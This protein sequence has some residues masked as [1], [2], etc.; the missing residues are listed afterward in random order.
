MRALIITLALM[1]ALPAMA[2]E[3]VVLG[4]SKNE[5]SITTNFDGSEI[6]IFGAV[7]REQAIPDGPPLEVIV[8]IAGP[9][10]PVVV[11]RKE[12]RYGIWINVD[13]V[14]VDRAPS[15]YAVVTSSPLEDILS[16]VEDQRN[17]VSIAQAIRSVGAPHDIADAAAFSESL[18]RIRKNSG[19]YQ[20][21]EGE[22]SI[23]EQTLFRTSVELPAALTEG[24][25]LTR[26][27]LTRGGQ[28]VAD[29]ETLIDVR[30]V[31][32][33]RWLYNMSREQ[34]FLY[35]LMSLAI[36]ISAGWGASAIFGLLRR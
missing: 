2:K 24:D 30:K 33:E 27:Y 13:S 36:A 7:K 26:I 1:L 8:T 21:R 31:G 23:E 10:M 29:Y 35:G 16:A 32:M 11:R 18:I 20:I 19:L 28:V 25:Y 22:V 3:E 9:S 15:F 4:L 17:K 6:L 34:S 12:K 5:V 14:E